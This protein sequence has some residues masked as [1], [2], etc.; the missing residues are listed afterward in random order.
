MTLE[1]MGKWN[2]CCMVKETAEE[3]GI[4]YWEISCL[5][6]KECYVNWK[7]SCKEVFVNNDAELLVKY[8]KIFTLGSTETEG[9]LNEIVVCESKIDG[10]NFRC[11]YLPEEDRLIF[12]SRNN[13]LLENTN[14]NNWKA[15]RSYKKAFEL[16]K[17]KF[18]P[19]IIYYS[20]SMQKHTFEYDNIPD[21]IGYDVFDIKRQ[22]FYNWKGCNH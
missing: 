13:I 4:K 14:P 10:G 1:C 2:E 16:F 8:P 19:D 11:R 3:D 12:G 20:E 15:I 17:D 7:N 9:I 18:I 21:T 22:E 5:E 6:K